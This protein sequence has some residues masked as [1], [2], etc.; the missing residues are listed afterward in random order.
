MSTKILLF[1]TVHAKNLLH[2]A[3]EFDKNLGI[4]NSKNMALLAE[5]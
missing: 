5:K 1:L 3:V 2:N 4:T